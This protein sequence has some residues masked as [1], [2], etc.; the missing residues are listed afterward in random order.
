M[1]ELNRRDAIR[2]A[3]V[4]SIAALAGVTAKVVAAEEKPLLKREVNR[5][6]CLSGNPCN[7]YYCNGGK[8]QHKPVQGGTR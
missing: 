7:P 8:L 5:T 1:S 6:H 4:T 3:S 2:L